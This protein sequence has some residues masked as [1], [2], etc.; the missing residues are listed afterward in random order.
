MTHGTS[1]SARSRTMNTEPQHEEPG[2]LALWSTGS[3]R[4][5][6]VLQ[7][8]DYENTSRLEH[9]VEILRTKPPLV[10]QGEVDR[11]RAKLADAVSGKRFVLHG[12]DCAERFA[13]CTGPLLTAKLQV[14]LQMSMVLTYATRTPVIRIGRLAGQYGKPRSAEFEQVGSQQLPVY[15]GDLINAIEPHAAARR[16]DPQ[17]MV[18]GYHHAAASLNY[19]RAL[20][21][22]GF[23]DLHH[24]ERWDLAF[25]NKSPHREEYRQVVDA[26]VDAIAFVE[27]IGATG[28]AD[29]LRRIE[30]YTSHEALLLPYE[31]GL[32]RAQI[33][34]ETYNLG[35][36]FLWVGYR[37]AF[38]ASAH[39]EYLRGIRNP[40]GTKVGPSLREDDLVE[41]LRLL[42]PN[43]EPGRVTVITRFG[44]KAV[45]THLPRVIEAVERSGHPVL[46]SCDPMHGN[47]EIAKDGHKTRRLDAVFSELEQSFEIHARMG[48]YLAGV[49]FELTGEA[50][51]ECIGGS[52]GVSESD[53]AECYETACDP[54]LNGAQALEMAFLIAR[55]LR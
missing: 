19:I 18:D 51:T 9:F 50:V 15:R 12:G 29:T 20:I 21:E 41:I 1:E 24:P 45:A 31:E 22:G 7:Q 11:L 35:A 33:N 10:A 46:W 48:T 47:T 13:D 53:L 49:H 44:E 17:R 30:L 26:I 55:L 25:I 8:P 43:R 4:S 38:P 52:G 42:D 2:E 5:R 23:A 28:D 3:W 34:T 14:L 16:P 27:T 36:H 6:H 37:T 32:T 40:V 39:V 54:R